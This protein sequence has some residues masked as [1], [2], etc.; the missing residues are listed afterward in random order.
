ME[1]NYYQLRKK[2][3]G[4]VREIV[5]N[6][7]C[8]NCDSDSVNIECQNCGFCNEKLEKLYYELDNILLDLKKYF[9][10]YKNELSLILFSLRNYNINELNYFNFNLEEEILNN[11][12]LI[13][14]KVENNVQLSKDDIEYLSIVFGTQFIYSE[15]I[16]N[17]IIL[18]CLNKNNIFDENVISS[19]ICLLAEN[20]FDAKKMNLRCFIDEFDDALG[21]SR[22][23][24][25]KINYS[26]IKDFMEG[27]IDAFFT[28]F[29][30][31]VHVLQYYRQVV[32]QQASVDDI[33]QIKER[34]ILDHNASF[35]DDNKFLCS[36]EQEAN[37]LG[38]VYLLKYFDNIGY[39]IVSIEEI[40][41][42]VNTDFRYNANDYIIS[43]DDKIILDDEFLNNVTPKDFDLYPQ[44]SYEYKIYDFKVT[45]KTLDE[46]YS[47][48]EY[49]N[50]CSE[51]D[52]VDKKILMDIYKDIISRYPVKKKKK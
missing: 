46:I 16:C 50:E 47:D 23:N 34:I 37:I 38:N 26:E 1:K 15:V 48:V 9:E 35:Y 25:I 4:I 39:P 24:I 45:S 31:Y 33:K 52:S 51:F 44:L 8:L 22:H 21:L 29:H 49:I 42:V 18:G 41:R 10:I 36:F 13:E 14:N 27:N 7:F 2:L 3:I 30:E 40:K 20:M 28:L 11:I 43:G 6:S 32:L 5:S 12:N 17:Y 19:A